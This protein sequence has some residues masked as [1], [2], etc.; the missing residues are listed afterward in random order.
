MD[1]QGYD[2]LRAIEIAGDKNL[3]IQMHRAVLL[4]NC[5]Y[6]RSQ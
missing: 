3:I 2:G 5:L 6:T 4:I 1:R